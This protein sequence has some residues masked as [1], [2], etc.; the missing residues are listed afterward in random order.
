M[1]YATRPIDTCI[2]SGVWEKP[3]AMSFLSQFPGTGQCNDLKAIARR[4]VFYER[5][6]SRLIGGLHRALLCHPPPPSR[7]LATYL[8]WIGKDLI[9]WKRYIRCPRQN[10]WSAHTHPCGGAGADIAGTGGG[11]F[12]VG[13]VTV[14][15]FTEGI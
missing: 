14:G 2:T 3:R 1:A 9:D 5:F 4:A 12:G 6:P 13:S 10:D 11:K 8:V 7:Q 15:T